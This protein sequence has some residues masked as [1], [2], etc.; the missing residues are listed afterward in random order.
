[1]QTSF[2]RKQRLLPFLVNTNGYKEYQH[3]IIRPRG[4]LEYAQFSICTCGEGEFTDEAGKDAK[5]REGDI[6]YFLPDTPHSY[7]NITEK[8]SVLYLIIGGECMP[9]FLRQLG[10][11]R[12]GILHPDK[13]T[14][15][16][17][18]QF[19]QTVGENHKEFM[20]PIIIAQLSAVCYKMLIELRR[21]L[22]DTSSEDHTRAYSKIIPVLSA[23]DIQYGTDL[24]LD[25]LAGIINITPTYLCRLFK[26][27]LGLSPVAYIT[28]VRMEN[29]KRLL[30]SR[31]PMPI[32]S[33]AKECGFSDP[34]YF[35]RIF[36]R[37]FGITPENYRTSN[38][39]GKDIYRG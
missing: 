29:A 11:L 17:F 10:Y 13:K 24:T 20:N 15:D 25:Y 12:S 38:T 26:T 31:K 5:V 1:M 22:F 3:E 27:A 4:M 35:T 21:F 34:G 8:W 28:N 30:L 18:L 37:T 16:E 9:T 33:V 2:Y 14:Y 7:R 19:W 23:I 39:Y 6:F 36:R 32:S